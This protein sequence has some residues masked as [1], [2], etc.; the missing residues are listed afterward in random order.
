MSDVDD[1]VG[2]LQRHGPRLSQR[3][4]NEQYRDPFWHERFGARGRRHADEDSDFHVKYLVRALSHGDAGVMIRYAR[5]LREVL[6]TRGMCTRHLAD[7]FARLCE[8]IREMRW[9]GGG[10]AMEVLHAAEEALRYESGPERAVQDAGDDAVADVVRMHRDRFPRGWGA[11]GRRPDEALREDID[12]YASY[13]ADALAFGSPATLVAHTSWLA[14]YL[15]RFSIPREELDAA[16]DL[17]AQ[18]LHK[19]GVAEEARSYLESARRA[20]TGPSPAAEKPWKP[21]PPRATPSIP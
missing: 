8:A 15:D 13:L 4:L 5:W 11:A 10:A 20:P 21:S 6:A 7:N 19:R 18:A 17:L 2:M 14:A 16:I 12:N 1:I 3:V 9:T